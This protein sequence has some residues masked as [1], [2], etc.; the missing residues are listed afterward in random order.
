[1]Y[2]LVDLMSD[3]KTIKDY[4]GVRD[5]LIDNILNDLRTNMSE[6]TLEVSMKSNLDV[7]ERLAKDKDTSLNYI[8]KEL[9]DYC[10]KVI[11]LQQLHRDLSDF[12]QYAENQVSDA[13]YIKNIDT[14]LDMICESINK[15]V[16]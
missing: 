14:V 5:L 6:P 2:L 7:L 10:F 4:K 12:Q 3:H 9:E 15:G 1:M 11:D 13:K 8:E 16:K